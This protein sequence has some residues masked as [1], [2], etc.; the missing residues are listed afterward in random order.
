MSAVPCFFNIYLKNRLVQRFIETQLEKIFLA[1][2]DTAGVN[3]SIFKGEFSLD[4]LAVTDTKNPMTNLFECSSVSADMKPAELL[5]GRVFI[6]KLGFSGLRRGTSRAESGALAVS[7]TDSVSASETAGLNFS[8]G[9]DAITGVVNQLGA[10]A[11]EIDAEAIL[12]QQKAN[13]KSFSII[14]DSK[15]K[16]EAYAEDWEGRV[17]V[18]ETRMSGWESSADYI[19]SVDADSFAT[20]ESAQ[21]T[22]KRLEG[23]YNDAGNDYSA[24]QKDFSEVKQQYAETSV[25]YDSIKEAVKADY[26]YIESLVTLP[27][28]D[29][30]DW[31]ASILEEQLSMPVKKYLSYLERGLEWYN[32]FKRLSENRKGNTPQRRPGRSLPPPADAPPSFVLVHAYA[33]G[34]EPDLSYR[35]DLNNLVSEPEKWEGEASLSVSLD[36]A[37]VGAAEAVITEDSLSLNVPAAPFDLGE[38]LSALEITEFDG[39]LALGSDIDWEDD[40][41]Y[42]TIDLK[43]AGITLGSSSPDSIIYRLISTSLES[44]EPL[45]A[46]GEFSWSGADGLELQLETDLDDSLGSA[47]SELLSEGADEGLEMLREYL[48]AELAGPLDDFDSVK[49]EFEK[50]VDKVENYEQELDI[51]RKMADEKIAEIEQA[52]KDNIAKQAEQLLKDNLPDDLVPDDAGDALKNVF[53]NGLK[54]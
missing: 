7:G 41:F 8:A 23:I 19:G 36:A 47:A 14:E 22:I 10:L 12:E 42:G 15:T 24:A 9:N 34:E 13:L 31:A 5:Q 39:V 1:E 40:A 48:G 44:V 46:A 2:V 20:L 43:A 4:Y 52:V 6:E 28:G 21:S 49:T 45:A 18:W 53:G 25:M 54:F 35:F 33:S 3:L 32:R 17:G 51:Y 11:G 50:Y 37:A 38:S 27:A 29:K 26:E 16:V 30:I